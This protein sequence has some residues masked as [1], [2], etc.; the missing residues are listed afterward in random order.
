MLAE[1]LPELFIN[2]FAVYYGQLLAGD[3]G[4]IAE[5]DIEGVD[6][7]LDAAKLSTSLHSLG[8]M[9]A[10]RT[11]MIKLNGGLG[12]SMGLTAAKSLLVAKNGLTFLDIIARQTIRAGSP[13]ILMNSFAT[14]EE[15]L[16]V[17]KNYGD[18]PGKLPLSFLQHKQPKVLVNDLSP[19]DWPADRELE[20]CPPGHGD[21]YIALETSGLLA[22]MLAHGY[23]YAFI[24]NADNLGAVL[25][26]SILGYMV[27]NQF[28]FL[29]EVA[30]R[31]V[32]DRKGGHLARRKDGQLILREIAQCPAED[33]AAF[34]NI[35]RYRYFNTNN[36]WLH[37]PTVGAILKARD[38]RLG[39][40]MIRN[41]KTIDPRDPSSPSVYQLETAMGSA[42]SVFEGAA[43]IRVPRSRFA[44][45][46]KTD[47]L[48]AVWSDAYVLT[49]EY[50]VV[51]QAERG[52]IPPTVELD[53][54]HYRFVG[55]LDKH[56]PFGAPSLLNCSSLR[57]EGEFVFGRGVSVN[58]DVLFRNLNDD[59][60]P[61]PA[62]LIVRDGTWPNGDES[63]QKETGSIA[64]VGLV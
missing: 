7:L 60:M 45:V 36:L 16:A 25:D 17:L 3:D 26:P 29:M 39:L 30:D 47:D 41:R 22:A 28:P 33:L 1:R 59:C 54:T 38:Y 50:H 46:K 27:A 57:V 14:E 44:P 43:A 48:L 32:A 21:L 52:G 4:L 64:E 11:V 8:Q 55:S 35:E 63:K 20:W 49:P 53:S 2:N 31:T 62:G 42:I 6:E 19:A 10:G 13:L 15:S 18:L 61:V 56:F 58:G 9:A 24:S 12:T 34:Q 5:G 23:E 40:P 51:L 37:L